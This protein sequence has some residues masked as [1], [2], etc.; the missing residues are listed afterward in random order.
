MSKRFFAALLL[1]LAVAVPAQAHSV[2]ELQLDEIIDTAAV[3]FEGTVIETHSEKDAA[4]GRIVTYTTFQVTDVLKGNVGAKHTIKQLGGE[5]GDQFYKVTLQQ[6]YSVGQS[7]VV[8][9]YG[10]SELGF[11]APVGIAQGNFAIAQDADGVGVSNGRDFDKMTERMSAKPD[12]AAMLSRNPRGN[13]KKMGLAE[14][15][16]LVRAHMGVSQ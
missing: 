7:A 1:G 8:F 6:K 3:A 14:F 13:A 16:Q 15:K 5:I 4:S 11:S 10:K 2:R 12:V 9:L